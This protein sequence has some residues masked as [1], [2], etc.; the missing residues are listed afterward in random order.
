MGGVL[1]VAQITCSL[2]SMTLRDARCATQAAQ[3]AGSPS[4]AEW[5]RNTM[6]QQCFNHEGGQFT[7]IPRL[8]YVVHVCSA[9]GLLQWT[10]SQIMRQLSGA[11]DQ[12]SCHARSLLRQ[13]R[14]LCL[15]HVSHVPT[16]HVPVHV[17]IQALPDHI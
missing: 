14:S 7:N 11:L 4:T 5:R 15:V 2:R 17:L 9:L 8:A 10:R 1:T 12:G 3:S 13:L 6:L 16:M